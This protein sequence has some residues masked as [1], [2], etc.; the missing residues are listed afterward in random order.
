L[1]SPRYD[2]CSLRDEPVVGAL[3][4]NALEHGALR[5]FIDVADRAGGHVAELMRARALTAGRCIGLIDRV[6]VC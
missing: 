1:L 2:E 6:R 4:A 3:R 5:G